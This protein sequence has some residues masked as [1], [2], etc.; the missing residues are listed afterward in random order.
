[1]LTS[2]EENWLGLS[3]RNGAHRRQCKLLIRPS[4]MNEG[5]FIRGERIGFGSSG[6]VFDVTHK[7]SS[8]PGMVMKVIRCRN[9]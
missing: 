6:D 2:K 5:S 3:H 9:D 8:L 7:R 1:M 4:E